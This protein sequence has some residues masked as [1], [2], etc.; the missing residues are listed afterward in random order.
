MNEPGTIPGLDLPDMQA[1]TEKK[2][3]TPNQKNPVSAKTVFHD[4]EDEKIDVK[5]G[6]ERLHIGPIGVPHSKEKFTLPEDWYDDEEENEHKDTENKE[7]ANR[8]EEP[9]HSENKK[10]EPFEQGFKGP[11]NAGFGMPNRD[12][13]QRPWQEE[14]RDRPM[15]GQDFEGQQKP[16]F[17]MP[18]RDMH[19]PWQGDNRDRPP[20]RQGPMDPQRPNRPESNP[21]APDTMMHERWGREDDPRQERFPRDAG[22]KGR[23]GEGL[24]RHWDDRFPGRGG[25]DDRYRD[26][27]Y[28]NR[29][30]NFGDRRGQDPYWRDER[31][32][33]YEDRYGRGSKDYYDWPPHERDYY[34][35]ERERFYPEGRGPRG[36][37]ERN[38]PGFGT[39]PRNFH[40][41]DRRN[42]FDREG[43]EFY[44][45]DRR[46]T[47]FRG[48]RDDFG[49]D[50]RDWSAQAVEN[51]TVVDYGHSGPSSGG[52]KM[53]PNEG[54][55][56]GMGANMPKQ[57]Q[58][59]I[60]EHVRR[61]PSFRMGSDDRRDNR[62]H[63]NSPRPPNLDRSH[64][65]S[66]SRSNN[67]KQMKPSESG[68]TQPLNQPSK[69]QD[70]VGDV[71]TIEDLVSVPGRFMRP[72]KMVIILRG[73]PGSGKTTLA[74]MIKDREVEN[75][76]NPP[77]I[78]CLDDYFMVETE[79]MIADPDT[80]RKVKTKIMEYEFEPELEE[81]YR[82]SLIKSFKRQVDDGFFPFII[83]DCIHNKVK[84][85]AEMATHAK[86]CNFEVYIGEL[87]VDQSICHRRNTHN[88]SRE[89]IQ[90]IIR[91]W[92][93]TPASYTRVD[94]TP[95][96]QDAAIEEVEMEDSM[97]PAATDKEKKEDVEDEDEYKEA[98]KKVY[99]DFIRSKWDTMETQEEKLDKLDG[100]R[101]AKKRMGTGQPKS[102]EDWL[103]LSEDYD[104]KVAQ[105]G[106][107]RVRWADVEERKK[108]TA[109]RERGFVLGQTD[110]GRM[111]DLSFGNNALVQIRY[112][113]GR[114]NK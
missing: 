11:Q 40:E 101:S 13:Q 81:S 67:S 110:W 105:P 44:D 2:N 70:E 21:R 94:L 29:W 22:P 65:R 85:F 95:F 15:F 96:I 93:K 90:N 71:V 52:M 41:R 42:S 5:L 3:M 60:P 17:G 46:D 77:R 54:S 86:K 83:V 56:L 47:Y 100:V 38:E 62:R 78:L 31:D 30:D 59:N 43:R 36:S 109:A 82:M 27:P 97:E 53:P 68:H 26:D 102:I 6:A 98:F 112:I 99:N 48:D 33:Y 10:D 45:R 91:Q 12:M 92:E 19:S 4:Q 63:E 35:R 108:Q 16:G 104:S 20:F 51:R 61:D 14:R 73:P 79:K 28:Y 23:W 1:P 80:G 7:E 88:H 24:D 76:G 107:K 37:F 32:P 113:E 25:P 58:A 49:R 66:P 103:Q 50:S 64:S 111:T 87:E 55:S 8:P 84:H 18:D 34:D 89:H 72:P 74:K 39:E 9:A 57:G 69:E 75:G 114:E 106:K